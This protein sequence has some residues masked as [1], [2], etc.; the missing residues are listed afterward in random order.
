MEEKHYD[1]DAEGNIVEVMS[2]SA[3]ATSQIPIINDACK[4][5]TSTATI[6]SSF[7]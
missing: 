1:V 6:N 5:I 2:S 7:P 4:S 3:P